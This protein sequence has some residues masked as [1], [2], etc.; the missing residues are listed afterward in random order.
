[1]FVS[2]NTIKYNQIN[3]HP[4][5]FGFVC[6]G[7]TVDSWPIQ[8][9]HLPILPRV[10]VVMSVYIIWEKLYLH[11]LMTGKMTSE[12]NYWYA[13]LGNSNSDISTTKSF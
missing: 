4:I 13:N 5:I 11:Q 1:M 6:Y 8:V 2:Y 3:L 7:V 10:T 9:K 12:N